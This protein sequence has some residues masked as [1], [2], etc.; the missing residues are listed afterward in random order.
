MPTYEQPMDEVELLTVR[1][2]AT[3]LRV[4]VS[5][6][7]RWV[8]DGVLAAIRLPGGGIRIPRSAVDAILHPPEY[9]TSN[10][11]PS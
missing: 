9:S 4:D 7:T 10:S 1:E 6:V 5:T 3:L 2:V 8:T 11:S